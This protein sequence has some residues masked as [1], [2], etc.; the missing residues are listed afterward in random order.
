M[1]I[2]I[3]N[4]YNYNQTCNTIVHTAAKALADI[5]LDRKDVLQS[6]NKQPVKAS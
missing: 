4:E 5:E 6:V 2:I 3:H 1:N